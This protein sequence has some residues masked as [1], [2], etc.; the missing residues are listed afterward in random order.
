MTFRSCQGQITG[1]AFLDTWYKPEY[2]DTNH[3]IIYFNT[4]GV[5]KV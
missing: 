5:N 1:V 3:G 4:T 2:S